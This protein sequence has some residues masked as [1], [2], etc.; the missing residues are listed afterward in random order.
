VAL[1]VT[2]GCL[3]SVLSFTIHGFSPCRVSSPT[4]PS[5]RTPHIELETP[6]SIL[7][8]HPEHVFPV[9]VPS[10]IWRTY[11]LR[12]QGPSLLG[13]KREEKTDDGGKGQGPRSRP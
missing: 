11:Y 3:T 9:K 6:D 4:V 2:D 7:S 13:K 1:L 10:Q 12:G 5:V 8:D